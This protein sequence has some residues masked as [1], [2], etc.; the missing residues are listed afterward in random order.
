[1]PQPQAGPGEV[2]IR[3]RAS[4]I[5]PSDYKRRA[6]AKAIASA[7]AGIN[8]VTVGAPPPTATRPRAACSAAAVRAA[9]LRSWAISSRS[10]A[11]RRRKSCCSRRRRRARVVRFFRAGVA[12]SKMKTGR[13]RWKRSLGERGSR[14][15]EE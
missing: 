13:M 11:W 9:C 12:P 8:G 4:G 2:L 14:E 6:N 3:L 15:W 5:N 7:V 1:M 10:A